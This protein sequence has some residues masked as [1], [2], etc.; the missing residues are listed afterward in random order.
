MKTRSLCVGAALR[1]TLVLC[2]LQNP[3]LSAEEF[4]QHPPHVH[5][6][7]TINVALEGGA[8]VIELDAPAVNVVGFEHVPGS[9]A[10]QAAVSAAATLFNSPGALFAL[11][12][13]AQCRFQKTA[14]TP[15]VWETR[16]D[17]PG[18]PDDPNEQH[19][20]YQVRFTYQCRSPAQL[21]WLVPSLLD[22]LCNI[23]GARLNFTT[24]RGQRS[25]VVTNG[26]TRVS[27]PGKSP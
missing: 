2:A 1:C 16:E 20:D 18:Q 6:R 12:A 23:T 7:V 26:H 3:P 8:L 17:V 9:D 4:V 13:Q 5:G 15:P 10:E 24:G 27:F 22:K 11:P 19:A 25:E 21:I 14:L